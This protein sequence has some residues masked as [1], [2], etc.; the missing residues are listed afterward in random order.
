MVGNSLSLKGYKFGTNQHLETI[1]TSFERYNL[2]LLELKEKNYFAA[3]LGHIPL[4]QNTP[5]SYQ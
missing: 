4:V 3:F 2:H 5:K 1:N